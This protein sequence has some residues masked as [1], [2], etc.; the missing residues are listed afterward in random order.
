MTYVFT[1]IEATDLPLTCD[2]FVRCIV[3]KPSPPIGPFSVIE[4]NALLKQIQLEFCV[5]FLSC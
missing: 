1:V 2:I 4:K 3:C 5:Y